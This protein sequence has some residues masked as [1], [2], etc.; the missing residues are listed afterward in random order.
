MAEAT[1]R[2]LKKLISNLDDEM[3]VKVE[4]ATYPTAHDIVNVKV[5]GFV[6]THSEKNVAMIS[7]K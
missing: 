2:E 7:I 3:V 4:D 6:S 5:V 1:V